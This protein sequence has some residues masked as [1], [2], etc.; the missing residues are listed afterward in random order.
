[1]NITRVA[2]PIAERVPT[3]DELLGRFFARHGRG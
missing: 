3:E 1:V 2:L